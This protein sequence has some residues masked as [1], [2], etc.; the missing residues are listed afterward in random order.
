MKVNPLRADHATVFKRLRLVIIGA[1]ALE[2]QE[3]LETIWKPTPGVPIIDKPKPACVTLKSRSAY[4]R[5]ADGMRVFTFALPADPVPGP[6]DLQFAIQRT[7]AFEFL[8]KP[9]SAR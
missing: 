3:R 1:H 9:A 7:V 5:Q 4:D 8:A 6:V 2:K